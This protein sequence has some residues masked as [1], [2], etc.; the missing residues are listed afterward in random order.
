MTLA[1]CILAI[2]GSLLLLSRPETRAYAVI[3]LVVGG[4]ELALVSGLLSMRIPGVPLAVVF[5][6]ALALVGVVG[7][8]KVTDRNAVAGATTVGIVG[9]LQLVAALGVL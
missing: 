5:G 2:L 8:L 6:A 1:M 9:A 3:G 7:F 4:L